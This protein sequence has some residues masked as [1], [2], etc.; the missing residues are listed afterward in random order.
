MT[1]RMEFVLTEATQRYH[2]PQEDEQY[3]YATGYLSF[4]KPTEIEWL[5]RSRQV[6]TDASGEQDLGNIDYLIKE[7]GHWHVGGDWGEVLVHTSRAPQITLDA[8]A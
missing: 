1:F 3:C 8:D 2:E 5:D 7:N 6:F 4:T